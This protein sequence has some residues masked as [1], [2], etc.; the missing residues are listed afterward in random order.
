MYD[1]DMDAAT[2][3][4]Q[5]QASRRICAALSGA[6]G[7]LHLAQDRLVALVGEVVAT[8][9]TCGDNLTQWL[10]WQTGLASG[11][12]NQLLRIARAME[13]HPMVCAQFSEGLLSIDQADL[14]VR[15]PA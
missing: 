14:G 1:I 2:A 9:A 4:T 11:H 6:C 13:S 10:S 15:V 5:E 12:L 8:G 3:E 7:E